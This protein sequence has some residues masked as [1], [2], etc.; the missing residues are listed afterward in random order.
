M[1]WP[2]QREHFEQRNYL[3][4]RGIGY[5]NLSGYLFISVFLICLLPTPWAPK[6]EIIDRLRISYV[7]WGSNIASSP[8]DQRGL[9]T[10]QQNEFGWIR[11]KYAAK[12][13][14]QFTNN[15]N[16]TIFTLQHGLLIKSNFTL[17]LKQACDEKCKFLTRETG[18]NKYFAGTKQKA[19]AWGDA[20]HV[21]CI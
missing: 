9:Y 21:V 16:N 20:L 12:E 17:Y 7:Y 6:I 15:N 3:Y 2:L 10:R 1:Q 13:H 19:G 14:L 5:E 4:L 8:K 18:R 11:W